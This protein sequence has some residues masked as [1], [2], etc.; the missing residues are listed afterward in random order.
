MSPTSYQTAPPRSS[1]IATAPGAV[2]PCGAASAAQLEV[3]G[4]TVLHSIHSLSRIGSAVSTICHN[5]GTLWKI[6]RIQAVLL[7]V[8]RPR[9]KEFARPQQA[10]STRQEGLAWRRKK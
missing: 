10:H 3:V 4:Q 6:G 1:I 5:N 7:A 2:K 8:F 9:F